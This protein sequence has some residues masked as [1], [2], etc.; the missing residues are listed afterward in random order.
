MP[1]SDVAD[2]IGPADPVLADL[3]LSRGRHDRMA[4]SRSAPGLMDRLLADPDT[5]VLLVHAA[6]VPV[7]DRPDG[8]IG[9]A[10]VPAV[11]PAGGPTG[12]G[13]ALPDGAVP[14]LLGRLDGRVVVAALLPVTDR[15]DPWGGA[16]P[17]GSPSPPVPGARW[18]GLR[19]VGTL[20]PDGDV[21]L[22]VEA[23]G[24]DGWHRTHPFCPRCGAPT[25]PAAAGHERRC[26]ADGSSHHP[27]SDPAVIMA[28]VDP[29]DRLLLARQVTW[30]D[31]RYSLLAG[32]VE[33]GESLE[34][35]VA[36]ET[37]EEAGVVVDHVRY[38]GSQPWPFPASL[39]VGFAARARTTDITVDGVEIAEALWVSVAE[40]EAALAD[41]T[42][43]LPPPL[44]IARQIIE[45]WAGG[46]LSAA[47]TWR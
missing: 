30:P 23:V 8:T 3:A 26:T 6:T 46:A 12:A 2:S 27:R 17:G 28:V 29:D 11:G 34:A 15:V 19:E 9:L 33:P 38:L 16:P 14:V 47:D 21:G 43:V 10:L 44:S 37:A 7:V 39:M 18:A 41:G 13:A 24:L 25:V 32:F 1:R 36:R 40:L 22:A 42:V 31:R 35:A 5:A 20:L 45:W 4:D